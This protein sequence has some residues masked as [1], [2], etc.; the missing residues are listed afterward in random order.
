MI[1]ERNSPAVAGPVERRVIPHR[2]GA[3]E[4]GYRL[5]L[6]CG[7]AEHKNPFGGYVY[8]FSGVGYENDQGCRDV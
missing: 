1:N 3:D 4:G 8:W 5:C 2:W 7:T 6:D